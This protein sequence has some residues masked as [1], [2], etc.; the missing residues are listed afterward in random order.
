MNVQSVIWVIALTL[1]LGGLGAPIPENPVLLGGGYAIHKQ[2][3]P[4]I[5]SPS[6][7]FL[8]IL[9]GDLLLFAVARWIFTHPTISALLTRYLGE[10]RLNRYQ[11]ALACWGAMVL[12]LARF[13]FGLRAVAYI[14]AGA[15]RYA[16]LRF[17]VVDGLGVAIQVLLFVGLGYYAGERIE[18]ARATG[19]RIALLL[20]ILVLVGTLVTWGVS[21][22][23]QKLSGITSGKTKN[24]A[25]DSSSRS[26]R[27]RNN[28]AGSK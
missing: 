11:K 13:T 19:G 5:L 3:C 4:T 2:V 14:V 17:V 15:A 20:G 6:L 28:D 7:W 25:S 21:A 12:F 16:W 1:F 22:I 10:K 18:W 8:A 27:I 23:V 26:D 9:C 24:Q